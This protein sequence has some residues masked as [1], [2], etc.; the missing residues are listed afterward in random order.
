VR[1]INLLGEEIAV[2]NNS[3]GWGKY[4]KILWNGKNPLGN[5][6]SSGIYFVV[7]TANHRREMKKIVLVR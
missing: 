6:V 4:N 1:I 3:Q 2:F 7:L 5:P